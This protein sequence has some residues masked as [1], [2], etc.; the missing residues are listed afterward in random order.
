MTL[1]T[2]AFAAPATLPPAVL[3]AGLVAPQGT[4]ILRVATYPY[5][6]AESRDATGAAVY[7][8]PRILSDIV[9][10]QTAIDAVGAG[11]VLALA[12]SD[13]DLADGDGWAADL[14]RYDTAIGRAATVRV[15]E[16]VV[17]QATDLGT[18]WLDAPTVFAG[19]VRAVRRTGGQRA[20][21]SLADATDRLNVALQP[22]LYAGSGGTE[23][24]NEVAGR[25]KPVCLGRCFNVPPVFL[26]NIDLGA[27]SLPTYQVHW[28]GVE[29]IDI[30]RI[31]GVTQTL[32][33]GTP[34]TGQARV[35]N[36]QGLFQLGA[37]PDGEV[38][39]D[40]R[41]DNSGSFVSSTAGVLDRLLRSLG[42]QFAEAEIDA[43]AWTVAEVDL[44]GAIGFF[45]GPDAISAAQAVQTICAG[46]GCVVAGG[47]TGQIRLFDPVV[48]GAPQFDLPA[49][50]VIEAEPIQL[51]AALSPRPIA[52]RVAWGRN[53]GPH[54]GVA[55]SVAAA[56][57]QRIQ[58]V[59]PP[60]ARVAAPG[61]QARVALQRT[62]DLA[63]LYWSETDANARA[64]LLAA[65]VDASP[66]AVRVVTDRYLGQV[67][68][69]HIGRVSYPAYGLDAGFTGVVLGW[70]EAIGA[71]RLEVTLLG[72]S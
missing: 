2:S 39:A 25:P 46:S 57:R 18:H 56:D 13:I 36:S 59:L 15:V 62:L 4:S 45:Q 19:V 71:R 58:S 38:R 10:E 6:S 8:P 5:G 51:P 9:V 40:V 1:L 41:G 48:T 20:R 66:R 68:L 17:P 37:S 42:A 14:D 44:P 35:F 54:D 61:N 12:A 24:G 30:V 27:G 65:W 60:L 22:T 16:A 69:G 63:G 31:R 7:W 72:L 34:T 21:V 28:R 47:R 32:V 33:G 3:P 70:R 43:V 23:G 64:T 55:G 26:G 29:A 52:A 53:W 49:E 11:G 50:W 67:D